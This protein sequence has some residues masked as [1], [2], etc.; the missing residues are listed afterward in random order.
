MD[1]V[2]DTD[3]NAHAIPVGQVGQG[4]LGAA[5][6]VCTQ[7]ECTVAGGHELLF[8]TIAQWVAHWNTFHVAVAPV[9]NCMVR[10]CLFETA[11]APDSLDALFRHFQDAH[12]SI[13]NGGK[14][15]N[16]V[17][18]VTR[19]LHV[20][21]NAHYWPP[22]TVMGELQCPVAIT[23]PT[24]AQLVS[25]TVAARWQR[26]STFIRLWWHAVG[27]IREL[28]AERVRVESVALRLPREP[29]EPPRSLILKL[30]LSLQMSGPSSAAVLM[31]LL[32]LLV[33]P[34]LLARRRAKVAKAQV[35]QRILNPRSVL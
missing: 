4:H 30:P 20:K 29:P 1:H 5:L 3:V 25:P 34:S 23:K 32:L 2:C 24:S 14:W 12:P 18:L 11:A 10:G 15:S 6:F 9:F 17:D 19:G 16:L 31:K 21:P 13:Y 7:P 27:P 28:N 35:T 22:A 26:V 8:A 33:R